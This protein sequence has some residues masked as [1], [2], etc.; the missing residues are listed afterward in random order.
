[1]KRIFLL[2]LSMILIMGCF[3]GCNLFEEKVV[4]EETVDVETIS[5]E[6]M[7]ELVIANNDVVST[8]YGEPKFFTT[9]EL[10]AHVSEYYTETIVREY[11]ATKIFYDE[12]NTIKCNILVQEGQENLCN[13]EYKIDYKNIYLLNGCQTF[14]VKF[15]DDDTEIDVKFTVCKDEKTNEWVM[16]DIFF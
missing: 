11:F 4:I 6:R 1:M 9:A 13:L 3:S 12:N 7:E 5:H 2:L 15:F 14:S 8:I 10:R 16:T